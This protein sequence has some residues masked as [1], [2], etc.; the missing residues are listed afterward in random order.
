MEN[1]IGLNTVSQDK[2][3]RGEV[4]MVQQVE[5]VTV[6]ALVAGVKAVDVVSP[7][8]KGKGEVLGAFILNNVVATNEVIGVKAV[9]HATDEGELT[10]TFASHNDTSTTNCGSLYVMIVGRILPKSV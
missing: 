8:G 2:E 9:A 3:L 10:L 1:I 5:L 7:F 4:P 6:G